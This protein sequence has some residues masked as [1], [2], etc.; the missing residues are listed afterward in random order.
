MNVL[1]RI[2]ITVFII[3]PLLFVFSYCIAFGNNKSYIGV[4]DIEKLLK[5]HK[6]WKKIEVLDK[7]LDKFESQDVRKGSM[8]QLN[9]LAEKKFLKPSR[10]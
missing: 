2:I 9:K 6:D 8:A 4:V 1:K 10:C 5:A 7:K 3:S